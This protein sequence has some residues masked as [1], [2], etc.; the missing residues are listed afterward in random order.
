MHIALEL[1]YK[2]SRALLSCSQMNRCC[3]Y[4]DNTPHFSNTENS[5]T[6]KDSS[7]R[8]LVPKMVIPLVSTL[9]WSL[10]PNGLVSFFLQSTIIVTVFFSTLM[11]TRCHLGWNR[12]NR[13]L[14]TQQTV[15][16]RHTWDEPYFK[17]SDN[18]PPFLRYNIPEWTAFQHSNFG[19]V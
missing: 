13:W 7:S 14:Q 12:K 5:F 4:N 11:P 19:L 15:K 10:L 2:S 16:G 9:A 3:L 1:D 6:S 18:L 8:I 17:T